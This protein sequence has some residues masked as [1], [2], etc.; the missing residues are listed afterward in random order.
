MLT[1]DFNKLCLKDGAR[2]LDIG[3]G[4]GRHAV[5]AASLGPFRV[6]AADT[7]LEDLGKARERL[8]QHRELTGPPPGSCRLLAADLKHLPF[9]ADS[10]DLVICSEVLEH[11]PEHQAAM[12]ELLRVLTPGGDLV[13]SVPRNFPERLCW[14]LSRQYRNEEGGHV[15]I[16]RRRE[17]LALLQSAGAQPWGRGFA[18]ALH[19]PY[20]WLKC[21][22]GL[23]RDQAPLV[24][25]Y[26]RF[27]IWDM[28][29]R[30]RLTRTL[31][32][33]LN[34]LIGKSLVLYLR[35]SEDA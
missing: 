20:W 10:F 2:V 19:A 4:S 25:L 14:A 3:C 8:A 33:L 31:E 5:A 17:L 13:V 29:K 11:I 28:M 23:K 18:H 34:P 32:A 7:N 35:K 30:P 12:A 27:L 22:L 6:V 24:K 9:G 1:V 26:H 16:Y 21:L 15:R